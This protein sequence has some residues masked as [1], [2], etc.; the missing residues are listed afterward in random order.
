MASQ[1]LLRSA[2]SRRSVSGILIGTS[3]LY[4]RCLG[5]SLGGKYFSRSSYE[6]S[7]DITLDAQFDLMESK[8]RLIYLAGLR[9][10]LLILREDKAYS[11]Y[12]A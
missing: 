11:Y 6:V 8:F 5:Y 12:L 9:L 7:R 3:D 1:I 2:S 4:L 10:A